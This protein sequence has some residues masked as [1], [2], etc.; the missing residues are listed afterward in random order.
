MPEATL[1][2][3]VAYADTARQFAR[4]V[5]LPAGATVADAIDASGIAE[6]A[7]LAQADLQNVGIF[8]RRVD[9]AAVLR[10]GDR[11]EIY[12]PLKIDPKEARRRRALGSGAHG[13]G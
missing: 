13:A 12:R 8:S 6:A 5:Q 9:R 10:D 7:G 3:T 4:E 1:R 11:V 2:V